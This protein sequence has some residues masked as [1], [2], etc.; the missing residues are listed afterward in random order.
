[1]SEG[2]LFLFAIASAVVTANAYYIHPIVSRV[3][4]HFGV[5]EAMIGAVPAFNQWS[6]A[7]GIFFLLPLGDRFSNRKLTLIFVAAQV[8]C[9]GVMALAADFTLFVG[10]STVLGFFTIAPYIL[11]AYVSKRVPVTRLGHS[12]AMLTA[13]IIFGILVA[14]VG[15]GFI[16]EFLD[17]RLVYFIATGLMLVVTVFLFF[18]MEER[19]AKGTPT[20]QP[21][22]V[23]LILSIFPMIRRYPEILI[24][25]AIQGLGFGSFLAVWLGI[26]LHL[27]SEE[28]G[29]G[30]DVPGY[31]AGL[32]IFNLMITPRL[33]RWADRTGPRKARLILACSQ[34]FGATLFGFTGHNLWLLIIP[35]LITNTG[36]PAM[37]VASRMTFLTE[38]PQIRTRLMTIYIVLMFVGG[39]IAS[40]IGTT[41]YH[42][43]GWAGTSWLAFG[44][45]FLVLCLSAASYLW[46]GRGER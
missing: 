43:A 40:W 19:E 41:V 29:F 37:D 36:G 25:G 7:L 44:S 24:S 45:A 18:I 14:R 15:A 10:A 35:I 2:G 6:L 32:T 16:G 28:M 11:P 33:G 3:A 22:Y 42:Y 31:L 39:G 38:A 34:L 1:M 26:G 13:G 27:P 9:L 12:T 4:D 30:T 8:V 21:G 20:D 23:S 17:W 46:K 5:S